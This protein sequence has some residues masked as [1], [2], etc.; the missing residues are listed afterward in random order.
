MNPVKSQ[1]SLLHKIEK[2]Q[3]THFQTF[4]SFNSLVINQMKRKD[5]SEFSRNTNILYSLAC[6]QQKNSDVK[7]VNP[8]CC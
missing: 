8:F 5:K 2:I 6:R 7:I 1:N 3:C 4:D